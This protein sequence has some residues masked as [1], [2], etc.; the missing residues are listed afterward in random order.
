MT[1][2]RPTGRS[3][4]LRI[5]DAVLRASPSSVVD[6]ASEGRPPVRRHFGRTRRRS[7]SAPGRDQR[8]LRRCSP[9]C[10]SSRWVARGRLEC[11]SAGTLQPS[12]FSLRCRLMI[13]KDSEATRQ[14][15]RAEDASRAAADAVLVA[16]SVA[17]LVSV[18]F[19]LVDAANRSGLAKGGFI[20]LAVASV[21]AAW[22]A[23]HS[24]YMLRYARLYYA[25]PVGGISF[26]ADDEPDY[27]DFAYVALTIG[28]T[29]Q[30]SDTD[31]TAKAD[32]AYRPP[33]RPA[34]ISVRRSDRG[35]HD[36]HR[37]QPRKCAGRPLSGPET[38][39]R[40]VGIPRVR[41]EAAPRRPGLV[42]VVASPSR[43][44]ANARLAAGFAAGAVREKRRL[45]RERTTRWGSGDCSYGSWPVR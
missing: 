13:R 5:R 15:A 37:R 21:V 44:L 1:G 7:S 32:P 27:R 8:R 11:L 20:G 24:V 25:D 36:Q 42:W 28:M 3:D 19:V 41:P 23:V 2:S 38:Q 12:S 29:F 30:V 17:S 22:L 40:A 31:L 43:R 9:S 45:T 16:A 26:H 10:S 14:A 34:L 6:G 4:R 39:P 35:N 18:A 33:T